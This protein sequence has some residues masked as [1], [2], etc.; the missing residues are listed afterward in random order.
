MVKVKVVVPCRFGEVGDVVEVT[1]QN[2]DVRHHL[3]AG[4]I[5]LVGG[6][7]VHEVSG[8]VGLSSGT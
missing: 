3:E 5:K 6:P 2:K 1:N 7:V 8:V 4:L